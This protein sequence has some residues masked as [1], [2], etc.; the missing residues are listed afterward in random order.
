[1]LECEKLLSALEDQICDA[2]WPSHS[3]IKC[4]VVNIAL[5]K[6]SCKCQNARYY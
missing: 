3:I 6:I 5:E 1:M 2:Q 4:I